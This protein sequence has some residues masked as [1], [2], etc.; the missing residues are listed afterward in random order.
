MTSHPKFM[1]GT[2]WKEDRSEDL[3]FA[4]LQAGFRAIDTANQRR[5][6]FEEGVGKGIQRFLN[7]SE[8]SR[9]D[10]FLQTKFTFERG[11]DHRLPYDPEAGFATQVRQSFESSLEHL[12][13]DYMDSF[14]LHGPREGYGLHDSDWEVWGEMEKL[15]SE[16]KTKALGVSNVSTEQLIEIFEGAKIKPEFAQIRT[17]AAS[18]WEFQTRTYCREKKIGYQGFSLLTANP[19]ELGH[20]ELKVL[21]EKYQRSLPEIVFR[22][23]IQMGMIPITGTT[24]VEH[25]KQDLGCLQ[26]ELTS[27]EVEFIEKLGA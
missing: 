2:A 25:M 10:L 17:F 13:T 27:S 26:M 18:G 24:S 19:N 5:H 7:E 12:N 20:P 22:A 6:Y 11:Q 21:S 15:Y 16:G 8:V 9:K 1:Y 4:A 14:V 3:T 23:C